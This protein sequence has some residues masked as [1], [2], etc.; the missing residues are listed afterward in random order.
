[1]RF[2]VSRSVGGV[3]SVIVDGG[4]GVGVGDVIEARAAEMKG[5]GKRGDE[6]AWSK[7]VGGEVGSREKS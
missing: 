2:W 4:G 5:G 7:R 6:S 1:M 3:G